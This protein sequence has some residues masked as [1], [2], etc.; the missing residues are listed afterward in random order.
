[1]KFVFIAKHRAVWPVERL[2]DALRVSR[3]GFHAWLN[4]SPSATS[5]GD[6]ELGARRSVRAT[7]QRR[8]PAE[9]L[10]PVCL[11]TPNTSDRRLAKSCRRYARSPPYVPAWRDAP[12]MPPSPRRNARERVL[13][14]VADAILRLAFVYAR[15]GAQARGQKP[16]ASRAR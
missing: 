16:N 4:R 3:S 14:Q 12:R 2:R 9:R 6:E 13:L 10:Q 1:M 5:R 15:H 8:L 7:I 11:V